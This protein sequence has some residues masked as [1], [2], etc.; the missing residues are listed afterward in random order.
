MVRDMQSNLV[1]VLPG[2]GGKPHP[3]PSNCLRNPLIATKTQRWRNA[4]GVNL[5]A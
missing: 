5:L 2:Q 3:D 1:H 4:A